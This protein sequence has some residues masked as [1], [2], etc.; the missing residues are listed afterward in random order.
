M[1]EI[2]FESDGIIV[3]AENGTIYESDSNEVFEFEDTPENRAEAV[4]DAERTVAEWA[5]CNG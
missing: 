4:A 2:L 1:R 5:G 3:Y